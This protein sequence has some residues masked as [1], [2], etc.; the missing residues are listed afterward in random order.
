MQKTLEDANIKLDTVVTDILGMTGRG[1][2][3]PLIAGE[4]IPPA[5]HA[6]ASADKG[7]A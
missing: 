1:I 6:G 3:Q 2:I 5:G 4:T 7:L